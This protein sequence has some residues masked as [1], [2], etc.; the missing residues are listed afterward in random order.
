MIKDILEKVTKVFEEMVVKLTI[1]VNGLH[2]LV[3]N[4]EYKEQLSVKYG[5]QEIFAEIDLVFKEITTIRAMGLEIQTREHLMAFETIAKK[6]VENAKSIEEITKKDLAEIQ[7][8]D[9]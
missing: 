9:V 7:G 6:F 8:I 1:V 4:E 5:K 3:F 2:V